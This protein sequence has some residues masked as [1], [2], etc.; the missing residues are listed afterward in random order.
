MR[1]DAGIASAMK[2]IFCFIHFPLFSLKV[3]LKSHLFFILTLSLH[4]Y[5]FQIL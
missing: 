5:I 3:P 1:A 4:A 2:L